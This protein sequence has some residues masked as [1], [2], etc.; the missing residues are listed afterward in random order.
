MGKIGHG[1]G[2]EWHLKRLLGARC[3]QL[4][5]AVLAA[6]GA[7]QCDW[8]HAPY[9]RADSLGTREWQGVDFLPQSHPARVAY[10]DFWPA[11]GNAPNWDAVARLATGG[12]EEWLLVEAKAHKGE[13]RSDCRART[14]GGRPRIEGSFAEVKSALG[15][16]ETCDWLTRSYQYCNRIA[17]LWFLSQQGIA[18]R[19]LFIYFTGDRFPAGTVDCPKS[20]AAWQEALDAQDLHVG[21][22][23]ESPLSDRMHR[24]FID[25]GDQNLRM[26]PK[27]ALASK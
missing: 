15:V 5:S 23:P 17:H 24:V 8:H 3:K 26:A 19:L 16:A 10:S 13:L 12:D 25:V 7:R 21:L 11:R 14:P 6:T 2:S 27:A 4:E 22:P 20:E 18:A 1:Y 9:G